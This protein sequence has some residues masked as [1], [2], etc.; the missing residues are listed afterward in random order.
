MENNSLLLELRINRW[1]LEFGRQLVKLLDRTTDLVIETFPKSEDELKDD[2]DI[3]FRKIMYNDDK[4]KL[5]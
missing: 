2:M 1:I 5:L 4:L 3:F